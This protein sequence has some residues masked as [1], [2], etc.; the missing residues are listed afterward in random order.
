MTR[1]PSMRPPD[2]I[3]FQLNAKI[4]NGLHEG[5]MNV[6]EPIVMIADQ[7]H[8]K[9]NFRFERVALQRRQGTPES[10]TGHDDIGVNRM[11]ASEQSGPS[12]SRLSR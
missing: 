2:G 5:S 6:R 12:A 1:W 10:G 11:F 4:A 7:S 9:R 3:E 8:A